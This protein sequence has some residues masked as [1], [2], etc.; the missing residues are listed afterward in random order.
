MKLTRCLVAA[1]FLLSVFSA[2]AWA[3]D[4]TRTYQLKNR[5]RVE[6]DDNVYERSTDK[7]DSIKIIEEAEFLM[8][9]NLQQTFIGLRY[10]PTFVWWDNREPDDTDFHHDLDAVFAHNFTPRLTLNL[11]DTFRVASEPE[12]VDR[13]TLV[14]NNGDY[15]YNVADGSLNYALQPSTRLDLGGRYT[16]LRFDEN[17]VADTDDYDIY[18]AGLTLRHELQVKSAVLGEYRFE[19][20]EYNDDDRSSESQYL[21][22]GI[23][24]IFNPTLLGN[25]R[26]GAQFKTFNDEDIDDETSP[27]VDGSLTFLPSPRTRLTAGVGYSMFEADVTSYANQDRLVSYLSLAHDLTARIALY[28]AGSYQLSEYNADQSVD[29]AA[30]LGPDENGDAITVQDGD[31]EVAQISARASYKLNRGN[32]LELGW[33]YLDLTSDLR[34][35]FERNRIE[36]GWRTEL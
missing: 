6:Y 25:L 32:W 3:A 36:L 33:Q 9:L 30:V 15:V 22:A 23:E 12:E 29:P 18:A 20:T 11:K 13:G 17:D 10:R 19:S 7:E 31:E 35:D 8:N 26:G 27:Y 2:G 16:L 34:E 28:L 1:G 21:G 24:Q 4:E 5:L 14:R